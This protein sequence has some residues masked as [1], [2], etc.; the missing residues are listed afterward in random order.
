MEAVISSL[1]SEPLMEN[2]H[3]SFVSGYTKAKT[4]Q[5]S[6]KYWYLDL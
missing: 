6:L 5:T 1:G 3:L 2:L 4:D